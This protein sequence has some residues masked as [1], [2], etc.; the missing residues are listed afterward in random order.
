MEPPARSDA[1][2]AECCEGNE[3]G[4][5][6]RTEDP[7]HVRHFFFFLRF[8]NGFQLLTSVSTCFPVIHVSGMCSRCKD[9]QSGE[10][11]NMC[12][13]WSQHARF[14]GISAE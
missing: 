10:G 7:L 2:G 5:R 6:D 9:I 13:R 1:E 8:F 14:Q 3:R 4:N 12:R 11:E